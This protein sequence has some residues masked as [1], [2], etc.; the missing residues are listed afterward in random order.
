MQLFYIKHLLCAIADNHFGSRMT[1]IEALANNIWHTG[2]LLQNLVVHAMKVGPKKAQT[3]GVVAGKRRRRALNLL[4]EQGHIAPDYEVQCR[5]VPVKDAVLMS[6]A[7]NDMR[8]PEHPADACD[9]YRVLIEDGRS[10]VEIADIYG[11][12]EATVQRRLKLA[13]VS[14][15]LV[16]L[17]REGEIK[18]RTDAGARALRQPRRAGGRVVRIGAV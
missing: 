5:I 16:D 10:I 14:P 13:R 15:K 1:G 12:S 2:G 11:V 9:A 17:F 7:E 8:E 3:F 18:H 6:V 4:V